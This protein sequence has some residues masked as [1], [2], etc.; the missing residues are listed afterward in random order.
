MTKRI[1]PIIAEEDF[2]TYSLYSKVWEGEMTVFIDI[3][4]NIDT[5]DRFIFVYYVIIVWRFFNSR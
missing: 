5:N 4:T 3:N 2:I 1:E